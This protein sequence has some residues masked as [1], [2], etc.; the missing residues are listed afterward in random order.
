MEQNNQLALPDWKGMHQSLVTDY[1]N[2]LKT[3]L[4][5]Y[6][7]TDIN[8]TPWNMDEL[9]KVGQIITK[10]DKKILLNGYIYMTKDDEQHNYFMNIAVEKDDLSTINWLTTNDLPFFRFYNK[11]KENPLDQCIKKLQPSANNKPINRKTFDS[12]LTCMANQY[13]SANSGYDKYKEKCLID[14]IALQ[15]Q[16]TKFDKEFRVDQ[17]V[18]MK[19][20]PR[21]NKK[22]SL[23]D[24]I[25]YKREALSSYYK[26]AIDELDGSTFTHIFTAQQNPNVLC[27]LIQRERASLIK[28]KEGKTPIDYAIN[29]FRRYHM[30]EID[31][32]DF[33]KASC[34][35]YILLNYAKALAQKGI[36]DAPDISDITDFGPCCKKHTLL[37]AI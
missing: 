31:S 9:V 30:Q 3:K 35:V 20:L 5:E 32:E 28:D 16:Y 27:E 26:N 7:K 19:L 24:S 23:K 8:I 12:M 34:C 18:L 4:E 11:N 15:L 37:K 25:R 1:Q 21:P 29:L 36:Q 10:V 22:L 13:S 17:I 14:I 33:K 2:I 6:K